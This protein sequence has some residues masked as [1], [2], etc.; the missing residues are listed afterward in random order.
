[1]LV[2]HSSCFNTS[3]PL[4]E[5]NYA[6]NQHC[7]KL[8]TLYVGRAND[9]VVNRIKNFPEKFQNIGRFKTLLIVPHSLTRQNLYLA[10]VCQGGLMRGWEGRGGDGKRGWSP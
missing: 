3:I 6:I 2:A 7:L 5:K 9:P 4:N 10:F 8:N 1:M